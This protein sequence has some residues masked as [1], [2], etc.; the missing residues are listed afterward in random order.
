FE[1]VQLDHAHVALALEIAGFIEHIR[2]AAAHAC[3]KVAASGAEHHDTPAGHVFAT[4]VADTF[5]NGGRA[6]VAHAEAPGGDA[7]EEGFTLGCAVHD[8]VADQDVFLGL[9]GRHLRWVN[10]DAPAAEPLADEVV[11]VAFDFD[12]HASRQER[13]QAL[14]CRTAQLD[15]HGIFRQP[16]GAPL[17]GDFT[18]Q[19]GADHTVDIDHRQIDSDFLAAVDGSSRLFDD[20]VVERELEAVILGNYLVRDDIGMRLS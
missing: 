5:H 1:C 14:P 3:S 2:D 6:A 9:E 19:H 10:H 18:R 15:V 17:L 20:L 13:T 7:A 11:A 12:G 8:D 4:V 16:L